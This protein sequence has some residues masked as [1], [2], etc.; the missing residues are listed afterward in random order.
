MLKLAANLEL[1]TSTITSRICPLGMTGSGKTYT[2]RRLLE[3]MLAANGF[4][5]VIDPK[6][7]WYGVRAGRGGDP[8][9][10][11]SVLIMGGD[12]GDVP[13]EPH[14]GKAVAEFL[15]AER[16]STILDTSEWSE[17]DMV[18][19]VGDFGARFYT[20]NR[21]SVHLVIDEADEFAPQSGQGMQVKGPVA[22]ALGACQRIQRRGRGRGIG[23]TFISQRSAVLS[24]S[25][26]SQAGILIAHRTKHPRDIAPIEDWLMAAYGREIAR[27]AVEQLPHLA[28]GEAI[29]CGA[30]GTQGPTRV[31]IL[32]IRTFDSMRTPEPGEDR[33]EPKGLADVDVKSVTARIAASIEQA[34]AND[35]AE[36]RKRIA[37]LERQ[38]NA[39]GAAAPSTADIELA[40]RE[41]ASTRDREW[42]ERFSAIE[43]QLSERDQ[44]IAEAAR[45]LEQSAHPFDSACEILRNGSA[46][47]VERP[48]DVPVKVPPVRSAAR[49]SDRLPAIVNV[50]YGDKSLS[51]PQ[52]RILDS[53][54][55]W[56]SVGVTTPSASQ[57][58]FVAGIKPTGGHFSNTVGPLSTRG[59]IERNGNGDM[60]LTTAGAAIAR[61]PDVAVTR[62]VYHDNIRRLL[63]KGPMVKILDAIIAF[64]G[65]PISVDEIGVATGINP[66]GGHFSNSIGPLSTLGLI[67]RSGGIVHPTRLLFPE[68]LA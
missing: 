37:E 65:K 45:L 41:A 15:A 23:T 18:R 24:K 36:L 31:K 33:R 68:G 26:I 48:A 29:V 46:A 19:F 17:A 9:Q 50:E 16:V 47:K 2:A 58:G 25:I 20:L 21:G 4:C 30:P 64:R 28:D 59:L 56:R 32:P 7:D 53:L 14:S 67:E 63:K 60:S 35:P 43:T 1:P 13:L 52:Q 57:V 27:T 61:T 42:N 51:R 66:G 11:H 3:E 10:G 5:I 40:R 22:A 38:L 54:A 12:H 44:R 49:R 8:R 39:K 55:W 62:A 6:G 34:K